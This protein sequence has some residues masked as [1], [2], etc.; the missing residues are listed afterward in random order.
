MSASGILLSKNKSYYISY[1]LIA[2]LAISG[3]YFL[4]NA[5]FNAIIQIL[6]FIFLSIFLFC[7]TLYLS[8]KEN[9]QQVKNKKII[10]NMPQLFIYIFLLIAFFLTILFSLINNYIEQNANTITIL[11]TKNNIAI[12]TLYSIGENLLSNYIIAFESIG[13]ILFVLII[14]L[15]FKKQKDN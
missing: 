11:E 9:T 1:S 7:T 14:Y 2:C 13:V 15:S 5:S 12:S 6:I 4:L 3:Y 10:K 8:P